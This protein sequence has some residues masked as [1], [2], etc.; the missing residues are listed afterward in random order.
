[1]CTSAYDNQQGLKFFALDPRTPDVIY[2][3]SIGEE[4]NIM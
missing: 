3:F 1:M 4:S 2:F